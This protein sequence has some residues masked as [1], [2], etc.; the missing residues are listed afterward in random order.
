MPGRE[1]T[2]GLGEGA[3]RE[4]GAGVEGLPSSSSKASLA[5]SL[6]ASPLR[7]FR[8]WGGVDATQP[9]MMRRAVI[10]RGIDGFIYVFISIAGV[11]KSW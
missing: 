3:G 7:L 11:C 2:T 9:E 10:I 8:V 4:A 6:W 1:V 5:L